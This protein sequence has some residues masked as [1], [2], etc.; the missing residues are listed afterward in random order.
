VPGSYDRATES[1]MIEDWS[2]CPS[3]AGVDV[4]FGV[5]RTLISDFFTF[6]FTFRFLPFLHF[7]DFS[8]TDV[9]TENLVKK[10]VTPLLK[11][12]QRPVLHY[13]RSANCARQSFNYSSQKSDRARRARIR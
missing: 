8:P 2:S 11:Q 10:Q 3:L 6:E 7:F 1:R 5:L 9:R 13:Q 4:R 12:A